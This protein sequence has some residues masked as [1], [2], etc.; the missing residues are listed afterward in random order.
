[1]PDCRLARYSSLVARRSHG[2]LPDFLGLHE[3]SPAGG[4]SKKPGLGKTALGVLGEGGRK[5]GASRRRRRGGFR[6]MEVP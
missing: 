2:A 5:T 1:L 4:G 6:D 3:I